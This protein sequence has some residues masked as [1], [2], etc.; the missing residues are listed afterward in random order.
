MFHRIGRSCVPEGTN[1][2]RWSFG[3]PGLVDCFTEFPH[4][5]SERDSWGSHS[6]SFEWQINFCSVKPLKFGEGGAY[7][8]NITLSV[9]FAF[10][11]VEN[12]FV[13]RCGSFCNLWLIFTIKCCLWT[14][15]GIYLFAEIKWLF[16]I[17]LL[18]MNLMN[19]R[20]E[21]NSKYKKCLY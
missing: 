21:L 13:F 19:F 3:Q 9:L 16:K 18:F 12:F 7:D 14:L 2:G 20:W 5:V 4:S 15:H 11:S 10:I 17:T 6:A 1:V 8:S